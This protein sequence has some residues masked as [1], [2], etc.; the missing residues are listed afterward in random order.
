M[1]GTSATLED[2][3]DASATLEARA[4][5]PP[6]WCSLVHLSGRRERSGV[7]ER[8]EWHCSRD[9]GG[10]MKERAL[11]GMVGHGGSARRRVVDRSLQHACVLASGAKPPG[12]K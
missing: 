3:D 6:D 1:S 7:R 9:H 10:E 4:R 2:H 11:Y 5:V 8:S 12:A